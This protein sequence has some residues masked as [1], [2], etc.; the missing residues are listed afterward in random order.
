MACA[1]VVVGAGEWSMIGSGETDCHAEIEESYGKG[2]VLKMEGCIVSRD[3]REKREREAKDAQGITSADPFSLPLPATLADPPTPSAPPSTPETSSLL[4]TIPPP[5]KITPPS[6]PSLVSPPNSIVP[7]RG[8][9]STPV[10]GATTSSPTSTV[11]SMIAMSTSIPGV[12][13]RE[14]DVAGGQGLVGALTGRERA[15]EAQG[16][17]RAEGGRDEGGGGPWRRF[18]KGCGETV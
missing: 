8:S 2:T 3:E 4:T 18:T 13:G 10:S 16:M 17:L 1:I 15:E 11:P 7:Q 14:C 12:A 6:S 5:S 9:S